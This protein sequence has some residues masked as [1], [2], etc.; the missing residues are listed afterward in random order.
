MLARRTL[1]LFQHH[2]A[3]TGT[4]KTFVVN[5]YGS[6]LLE[7]IKGLKR[8]IRLGSQ[9]LLL[10]DKV[11]FR[12]DNEWVFEVDENRNHH[13]EMA[14]PAV[15][16][17]MADGRKV[18]FYNSL[19]H[20][21]RSLVS[22]YVNVVDVE[23]RNEKGEVVQSQVDPVWALEEFSGIS[24]TQFKLHFVAD[25]AAMGFVAFNIRKVT[26]GSNPHHH[27]SVIQFV[28]TLKKPQ[29]ETPFKITHEAQPCI[30]NEEVKVIIS[31]LTGLSK[32]IERKNGGGN[33]DMEIEFVRYGTTRER[34]RSGAYLFIPGG[35]AHPISQQNPHLKLTRGPL[36]S[37]ATTKLSLVTHHIRCFSTKAGVSSL[38]VD[39]L[40]VVD[41]RDSSNTELAMRLKTSVSNIDRVFHTDMNGF[42]VVDTV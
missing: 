22:V 7:S 40:N 10:N 5:D 24:D 2:D 14:T 18:Y 30:E 34:D 19:G 37:E 16:D 31:T 41:I 15:V 39:V 9:Y 20:T 13:S 8:V 26:P 21:R 35:E 27:L 25:I 38:G 23:V 1:G 32:S 36:L 3:I 42:Q 12:V 6:K 4:S 33:V 17:L 11:K 29:K 28:N